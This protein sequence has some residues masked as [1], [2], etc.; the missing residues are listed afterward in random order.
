MIYGIASY[1]HKYVGWFVV[2]LWSLTI[3]SVM[4][5][6]KRWSSYFCKTVHNLF[7]IETKLSLLN[8]SSQFQILTTSGAHFEQIFLIL[9]IYCPVETN[10]LQKCDMSPGNGKQI[11]VLSTQ[12]SQIFPTPERPSYISPVLQKIKLTETICTVPGL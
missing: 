1:H 10:Y 8:C 4:T 12:C 9:E 5:L 3:L 6:M 11:T 7:R 2:Q